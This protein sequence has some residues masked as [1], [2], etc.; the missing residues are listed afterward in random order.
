MKLGTY[1]RLRRWEA[2]LMAG[3]AIAL[4]SGAWLD[5]EQAALAE[6]VLRLHV[7]AAS[8]DPAD[9]ALK[10]EV[11]DQVLA[12]AGE[13]LEGAETVEEAAQAL[14]GA[15]PELAAAGEAAV[16]AAGRSEAVT[17][18]LEEDVWFP[19]KVY[20]DFA[21]P[22]G[23]YTALR[24]VIGEGAGANWWC[25]VFPPLC[26]GSV[27]ETTVETAAGLDREDVALITGETQGYVVKFKAL[28]LWEG[29]RRWAEGG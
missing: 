1:R 25:V 3:V 27:A 4:L 8:D 12:R 11:R 2:A 7:I 26:L 19:T 10:L 16:R 28:E 14:Q 6:K 21:L 23:R 24:V 22:Q 29:L 20:Q 18:S 15:L 13:V 5:G 17:A 9:Q